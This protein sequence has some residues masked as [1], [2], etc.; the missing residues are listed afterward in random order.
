MEVRDILVTFWPLFLLQLVLI[1]WALTD[2][3]GRKKVKW[4]PKIAWGLIIFFVTF[5]AI[6]YLVGG[7]GEE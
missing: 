3:T 1:A 5:G 6:I 4:L 7:R 2:L